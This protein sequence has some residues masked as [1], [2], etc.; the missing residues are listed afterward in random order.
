[1]IP[2]KLR[3]VP[4]RS[5]LA[6]FVACASLIASTGARAQEPS[7]G[8][9][10]GVVERDMRPVAT[11]A[12]HRPTISMRS[13]WTGLVQE[14]SRVDITFS[15][16]VT[17]FELRDIDVDHAR[18]ISNLSGSGAN[19][20]VTLATE[21][22]YQG[23]V[24]IRIA[25]NVARASD[26]HGNDRT[27]E[28]V[29]VDNKPP[30]ALKAEV[31]ADEL[32]V[33]FSEVLN[34]N[35]I[36]SV[37]DFI[38]HVTDN[39]G[40]F[41]L[42]DVTRVEVRVDRVI[43]TLGNEVR[44]DDEVDLF[45]RDTGANAIE[46]LVG[47]RALRFASELEVTNRTGRGIGTPGPPRNLTARAVGSSVIELDWSPPLED[48]GYDVIGY[49]IEVSSNGGATWSDLVADTGDNE[50]RYRH[51][52]LAAGITRHYRVS[53]INYYGVGARSDV[54]SA[55]T[56]ERVP[57]APR[58]LTARARGTSTIELDWTAPSS[59]SGGPITGYRIEESPNGNSRWTVLEADTDSRTTEYTHTRLNPGTTRH[60]RVAAINGAGRGNWSSVAHATTD[61]TAP[62]APSGLS[63][64]P[65]GLGG[66]NQLLLT[67]TRPSTDGG[68][69]IRGYLIEMSTNGRSGWTQVVAN[70][71]S[72]ATNYVHLRLAPATTRFYRVAAINAQGKGAY[73]NV[74]TG[75]TNAARPGQP[76]SL[77]ARAAGP[78][79][80][81]LSW[82]APS[83]DAGAAIT[84]YSIRRR[85]SNSSSWITI[86]TNTGSTATTFQDTDTNLEPATAYL[87]QVRR[88]QLRGSAASGR[89]RRAHAR[90]PTFLEHPP[91]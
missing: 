20:H 38:V 22:D 41:A 44:F 59:G 71:R 5:V 28:I 77:G 54:D 42:E 84:G 56:Q 90:T 32:V 61:I 91:T 43:L 25:A 67:W 35:R 40:V 47:N 50:T 72:T 18:I 83:S 68:S 76:R 74:A 66:S 16:G 81:T 78:K 52:G 29:Y 62:D 64:V 24:L 36:P 6:A 89:P 85:A 1:M 23:P 80:I 3:V 60:Y 2:H 46:D 58:R 75:T 31:D 19:Y 13:T 79:S 26:Y 49:R 39:A 4:A 11:G 34:G 48:G 8:G 69:P 21:D 30:S 73:S 17:G 88:D 57:N 9:T 12:A 55:T 33:T 10:G 70:T 82:E 14:R 63:A 86:R 51:T 27:T 7:F 37:T 65:S 45:Y 15:E 87:Y 53:A